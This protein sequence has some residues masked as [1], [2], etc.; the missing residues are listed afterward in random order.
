MSVS[1]L[2]GAHAVAAGTTASPHICADGGSGGVGQ[3]SRTSHS[4]PKS[5]NSTKATHSQS[6]NAGKSSIRAEHSQHQMPAD[7]T[8]QNATDPA[9]STSMQAIPGRRVG[10]RYYSSSESECITPASANFGHG[11]NFC[12]RKRSRN[13]YNNAKGKK[14]KLASS[15]APLQP[16]SSKPKNYQNK[17]G[18]KPAKSQ[19]WGR[20][21]DAQFPKGATWP[22]KNCQSKHSGTKSNFGWKCFSAQIAESNHGPG[23]KPKVLPRL[24]AT[25]QPKAPNNTTEFL[26]ADREERESSDR[27]L[28]DATVSGEMSRLRPRCYSS[29]A[30]H[31]NQ[32]AS[33]LESYLNCSESSDED[34]PED[35]D[36]EFDAIYD[37]ATL[38]RIEGLSRDQVNRE[39]LNI[40]KS[41]SM[42][43][44]KIGHLKTENHRLK[45]LLLHHG[46]DFGKHIG[47]SIDSIPAL[48]SNKQALTDGASRS[49][50]EN[51]KDAGNRETKCHSEE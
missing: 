23:V 31:T 51:D 4:S 19:G 45:D 50:V 20:V 5:P 16:S 9:Q 18:G 12:Q 32:N 3:D 2:S 14:R 33:A 28:A 15:G 8:S 7:V 1:V 24:P 39:M 10:R 30:G 38:E 43:M 37:S 11:H 49:S 48:F 21:T 25:Q 42:L 35:E 22:S 26:I 47:A 41:N 34:T 27:D 36:P 29:V 17:A 13:Q 46:I 6:Y 44:D 40:N